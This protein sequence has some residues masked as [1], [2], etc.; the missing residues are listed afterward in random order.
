MS[1]DAWEE[2]CLGSR[3]LRVETGRS[4]SLTD[5]PAS[6]GQ[7]GV[8]KVSAVHSLG[9]RPSENKAVDDPGLINERFEVKPGDLLFSRANTP[10]LVA[11]LVSRRPARND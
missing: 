5:S 6:P 7:W 10:E 1:R 2:D 9:Y 4:P 11:P 3:L 8:L